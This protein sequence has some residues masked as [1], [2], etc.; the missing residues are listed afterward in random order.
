MVSM[1]KSKVT[2]TI[3]KLIVFVIG[4][5][6]VA[7][8]YNLFI[9]P[10]NLVIG[11][12]SGIAIL[13]K[14]LIGLE[15]KLFIYFTNAVLILISFAILGNQKTLRNII[16]AILYPVFI[17]LTEP[18]ANSINITFNNELVLI[19]VTGVL[20]GLGNGL[21]YKVGF[22]MGGSDIM[23]LI[24]NEKGKVTMG[25]SLLVINTLIILAS[26]FLF[27]FEKIIYAILIIYISSTLIDKILLGISDSK[28]FFIYTNEIDA[29]KKFIIEEIKTG[30][31][32][33]NVEGGYTHDK[34]KMLMCVVRT[35]D[36]LLF[37]EKI[38]EIDS[39]V[40]LVIND[41]Y[42]VMGGVKRANLPF[43]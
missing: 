42:E 6:I 19:L 2:T 25:K 1:K 34:N 33:I 24:M 9:I 23:A 14:K 41:C 35:R 22:Y 28:M 37:K 18:L 43:I 21:A 27:G 10:N 30:V 4:I 11:G 38:V 7:F 31:T 5:F 32:I 15:P 3:I 36:Y 29:I 40:F 12:T 17:S 39:K 16:G 26:G 20:Y 13:L 8:N